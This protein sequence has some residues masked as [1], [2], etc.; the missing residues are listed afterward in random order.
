MLKA[1]YSSASQ[2][3]EI[4]FTLDSKNND[5]VVISLFSSKLTQNG[6]HDILL[7]A[8][9]ESK[10][11]IEFNSLNIGFSDAFYDDTKVLLTLEVG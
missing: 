9:T 1:S 5:S 2:Q 11:Q 7:I 3:P 8:Q 10:K 6:E 4:E